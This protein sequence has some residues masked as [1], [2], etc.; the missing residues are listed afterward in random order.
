MSSVGCIEGIL[1]VQSGEIASLLCLSVWSSA[2]LLPHIS[3]HCLFLSF[4]R[5]FS[6]ILLV[7]NVFYTFQTQDK[8]KTETEEILIKENITEKYYQHSK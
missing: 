6:G 2:L 7:I 1:L 5:H 4:L 3:P 8:N